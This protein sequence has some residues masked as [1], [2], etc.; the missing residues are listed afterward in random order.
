MRRGLSAVLACA[1]GLTTWVA[2][3]SGAS[4][5]STFLVG[6]S[7][8]LG[9]QQPLQAAG[10]AVDAAVSRSFSQGIAV[11]RAQGSALPAAVI[12]HLGTNSGVTA[13]QCDE[14]AALV[15]PGRS[16]S[17]VTV[18]IPG[19]PQVAATANSVLASCAARHRATLVD[20][21]GYTRSNPQ[22]LCG[23]GIHVSCGGGQAYAS[24]VLSRA[25]A[26]PAGSG[27]AAAPRPAATSTAGSTG[28]AAADRD[29][30]AAAAQ[31]AA[32]A[33]RAAAQRAAQA[34]QQRQAAIL[35]EQ[36]RR[37]AEAARIAAIRQ[38]L[39]QRQSTMDLQSPRE[40]DREVFAENYRF[41]P[42]VAWLTEPLRAPRTAVAGSTAASQG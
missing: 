13:G 35:A 20:W 24:F 37:A 38:R 19:A 12:V 34:E 33:E 8:A 11:L 9:A 14:L 5:A 1:V 25:G 27:P 10:V 17:L 31:Q 4:A 7:V 23:D 18:N 41:Q 21:A 32:A 6:D 3:A 39:L 26:A 36:Q 2:G 15:G 22:V 29:S 16:L 40:V 42:F 30:A 28:A